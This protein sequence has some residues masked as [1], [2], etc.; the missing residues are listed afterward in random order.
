MSKYP[1]NPSKNR[2]MQAAFMFA[3]GASNDAVARALDTTEAQVQEWR[4]LF[5]QMERAKS[6]DA[7]MK[8]L[9]K[10]IDDAGGAEPNPDTF[11]KMTV[12]E[13]IERYASNHIRFVYDPFD[14]AI[15]PDARKKRLI[16]AFMDCRISGA[17][18]DADVKQLLRDATQY[19]EQLQAQPAEGD[20]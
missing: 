6:I 16:R 12:S 8:S 5:D 11:T 10:A 18:T 3:Y 13:L 4:A 17:L 9:L 19:T 2:G 7:M 1:G 20:F 15:A 14:E